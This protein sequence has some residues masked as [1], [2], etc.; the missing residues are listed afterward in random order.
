MSKRIGA[1]YRPDSIEE[2]LELLSQ[3]DTVPLGGGTKLLAGEEVAITGVVDLQQLPLTDISGGVEKPLLLGG[4]ARLADTADFLAQEETAVAAP[5]LQA[6]IRRAGANS[7]RNMATMGGVVASRL[8]NSELLA[9]L[10]VLDAVVVLR[11]PAV[12]E[13]LLADYLASDERPFGLITQVR[14][15]WSA[16]VG[17]SER[18]ARTPAD[19]PIV[20][21]TG[22]RTTGGQ[23]R[24]AATGIA[25]RPLRLTAA[26]QALQ[27]EGA[28]AVETAVVQAQIACRHPGDFLG[29][30]AYRTAMAGVL[31]RRVL[32]AML[33][34]AS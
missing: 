6:A 32:A 10:L 12:A 29:D 18:V 22:W 30:T 5:L 23:V 33:P 19:D 26:E 28:A 2:A 27:N 3:P 7:Y 14:L 11:T 25:E 16:G 21:V 24:L 34:A 20:S 4:T 17:A 13:M 8:A 15:P 1:Y 9:A 31:T